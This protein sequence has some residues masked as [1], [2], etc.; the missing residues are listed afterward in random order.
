MKEYIY[1]ICGGVVLFGSIVGVIYSLIY[2][3]EKEAG[4]YCDYCYKGSYRNKT[5]VLYEYGNTPCTAS[6]DSMHHFSFWMTAPKYK[7]MPKYV[8]E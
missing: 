2:I 8:K 7:V 6:E 1:M 4:Y 3:T 5:E